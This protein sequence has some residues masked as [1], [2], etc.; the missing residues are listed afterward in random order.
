MIQ[1]NHHVILTID[2]LREFI[3]VSIAYAKFCE[4]RAQNN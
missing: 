4:S 1:H 3:Y 2:Q